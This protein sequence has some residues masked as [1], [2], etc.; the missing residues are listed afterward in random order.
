M[1][2]R[3]HL[4][5]LDPLNLHNNFRIV[6]SSTPRMFRSTNYITISVLL[7]R[8][9][10]VCLDPLNLHNNFCIVVSST[11]RMIRSTQFT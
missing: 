5:C 4:V 7:Y 9:H 3:V 1:L 6:V 8:V 2:Y 11:P 10:L